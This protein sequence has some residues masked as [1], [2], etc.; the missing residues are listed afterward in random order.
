M[1][2]A[3]RSRTGLLALTVLM[4]GILSG[5]SEYS[6]HAILTGKLGYEFVVLH[7]TTWESGQGVFC[8]IRKSGVTVRN[9]VFIS[10]A[11][12][13]TNDRRVYGLLETRSGDVIGLVEL[14]DGDSILA[15]FDTKSQLAYPHDELSESTILLHEL[16]ESFPDRV[17]RY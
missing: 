5:C 3:L 9:P 16:Q 6:E 13:E 15:T 7:Q 1:H 17:L 10:S 12:P 8:E 2:S 11:L 14:G 4:A